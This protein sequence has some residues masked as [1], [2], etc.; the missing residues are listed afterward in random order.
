M[1]YYSGLDPG[2]RSP[3]GRLSDGQ[4]Q[5]AALVL[6]FIA[7]PE[8]AFIDEPFAHLDATLRSFLTERLGK[9]TE[10]GTTLIC[11]E[12]T[13]KGSSTGVGLRI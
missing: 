10:R 12:V 8:I 9:L 1:L 6:V 13:P 7:K 11:T 4:R 5:A 3:V 2:I